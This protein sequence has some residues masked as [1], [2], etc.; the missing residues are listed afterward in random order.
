MS[1]LFRTSKDESS[2]S[3]NTGND[4]MGGAF[5]E[6]HKDYDLSEAKNE[7]EKN[8][9]NEAVRVAINSI[10]SFRDGMFHESL[11]YMHV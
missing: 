6:G 1:C 11:C 5:K 8:N 4:L 2:C 9:V 7:V 10:K 3:R